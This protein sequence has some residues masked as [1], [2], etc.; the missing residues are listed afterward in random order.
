M[1]KRYFKVKRLDKAKRF[2]CVNCGLLLL[3]NEVEKHKILGHVLRNPIPNK[4]LKTPTLLFSPLE[5]NKTFA[6]YL[7]DD[8]TV[9]FVIETLSRMKITHVLCIGCPRIHE[10]VQRSVTDCAQGLTSL[11][12]DL[13]HRYLQIYSPSKFCRYNMMNHHFFEAKRDRVTYEEFISRTGNKKVAMVIDP[14]FGIMVEAL[15]ATLC[16]IQH[17]WKGHTDEGSDSGS[18][19]PVFWFF[20]Y[21]MEHRVLETCKTFTMLDYKVDYDNHALFRGDKGRKK[22]SPVRIFT[23]VDPGDVPLPETDGYWYCS[24]CKR[25]SSSV[26]KHC[27][28]CAACTTKD[29]P[30]Y[31]HCEK[32]ERCVK[33]SRV[34]CETCN[35]C[36]IPSHCCSD[37]RKKG[38]HICGSL[39]HKRR[40]CPVKTED[41]RPTLKR[42]HSQ[43]FQTSHAKVQGKKKKRR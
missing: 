2:L 43:S 26:N 29:G 25:Y 35:I 27:E 30:T 37:V 39:D 8:R 28:L 33:P 20:P 17:E 16:K 24:S 32:C 38:C 14:P 40:D 5:D 10:A 11:L 31:K 1:R 3:Q 13:D 36:D 15:N 22:G 41:R 4:L 42:G 34:H 19:M 23:N 12:L 21:F 9:N 18:A 6:Q 7:F